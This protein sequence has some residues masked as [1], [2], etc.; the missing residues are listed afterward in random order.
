MFFVE[1]RSAS[2]VAHKFGYTYRGFTTIVSNFRKKLKSGDV[3]ELYFNELKP[4][5]REIEQESREI[6]INLRKKYYSVEDIKVILIA[7]DSKSQKNPSTTLYVN[8]GLYVCRRQ[9]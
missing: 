6:I 7:K 9:N 2:E 8:K 3:K 1:K 4:G 5:R